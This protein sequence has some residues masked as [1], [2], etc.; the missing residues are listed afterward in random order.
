[1]ELEK[2][3][4]EEIKNCNYIANVDGNSDHGRNKR[5]GTIKCGP[6][7]VCFKCE[8][9]KSFLKQLSNLCDAKFYDDYTDRNYTVRP[10]YFS[11]INREVNLA[12]DIDLV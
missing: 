8:S 11:C 2:L 9:T 4:H 12:F 7:T 10:F 6:L 3:V 1:M 5:L